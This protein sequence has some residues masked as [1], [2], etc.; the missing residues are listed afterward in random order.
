MEEIQFDFHTCCL[1]FVP[2]HDS[3]TCQGRCYMQTL[4]KP[5]YKSISVVA[6]RDVAIMLKIVS[7]YEQKIPR[8][9]TADKPVVS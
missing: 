4:H 5:A 7:E 9:Q 3:V 6:Y 2:V 8:S 1:S